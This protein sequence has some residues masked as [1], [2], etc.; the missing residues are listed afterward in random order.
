MQCL[1]SLTRLLPRRRRLFLPTLITITLLLVLSTS[2]PPLPTAPPLHITPRS[3]LTHL[4]ANATIAARILSKTNPTY[5]RFAIALKSGSET[6]P[7]RTPA[8]FDTFLARARNVLVVGESDAVSEVHGRKMWDVY[9]GVAGDARRRLGEKGVKVAEGRKGKLKLD[10]GDGVSDVVVGG[11]D[12]GGKSAEDTG[13]AGWF[14]NEGWRADAHKNLPAFVLLYNTFPDAE[15]YIMIDDDSYLFL[16]SLHRLTQPLNPLRA[17]YLGQANKFQGCDDITRMGAGPPIAQGGSG[18]VLSQGAMR[19]LLNRVDTC[20]VQY[21]ECWAGDIR[22]ALCLRDGGV[23]LTHAR[24]FNGWP[25]Q[26]NFVF[27]EEACEVPVTYHHVLPEQMYKLHEIETSTP[28]AQL[29]S[30]HMY[31]TFLHPLTDTTATQFRDRNTERK[32]KPYKNFRTSTF[33]ECERACVRD[34]RR[35]VSWF[36]DDKKRCWLKKT[37]GGKDGKV[38]VWSGVIPGRYICQK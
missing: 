25:P 18:I 32:G 4:F 14:G 1:Q 31:H 2:L 37:P 33:E 13:K 8:Q 23:R 34:T 27:S 30:A 26:E 28:H 22:T 21:E 5:N 19:V 20:I 16:E 24:G 35:C 10:M 17:H 11:G 7:L 9:H 29:T 12:A 6:F 3:N 38:G 36:H 15:W